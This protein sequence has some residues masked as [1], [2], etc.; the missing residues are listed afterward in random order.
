MNGIDK[1]AA[2]LMALGEDL[3]GDVLR[4]LKQPEIHKVTAAMVKLE[5]V[6]GEDVKSLTTD[7]EEALM[8]HSLVGLDGGQYMQNVL[9]K[10][11]GDAKA[12]EMMHDFLL[13]SSAEGLEAIRVMEPRTISNIVQREHPQVIAFVLAS[14]DPDRASQ[15]LD[16]IPENLQGEILYRISTMQG[17]HPNVVNELEEA[18]KNHVSRNAAG[19]ISNVGGLKFAAEVI[20]RTDRTKEQRIMEHIKSIEEP[21]YKAIEEQLFVFEDIVQL[22]DRTLQSILKEVT[23]DVLV[24]A[25]RATDQSAQDKFFGNMSTR[26]A[27]I[28]KEEMEMRGPVRLKEVEQAQQ[29]LIAVAKGLEQAGKITLGKGGEDVYV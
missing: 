29:D 2:L 28:I 24:V 12:S 19:T 6:S 23:T 21:I 22:D 4:H 10:T 9:S 13:H 25:L 16:Y 5:K 14:L 27:N 20:N 8:D 15:V 17:I 3:A 11:H 1:S 26:A 7:Y 18:V